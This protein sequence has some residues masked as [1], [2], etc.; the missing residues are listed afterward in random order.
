PAAAPSPATGA[1]APV[2]TTTSSTPPA[3]SQGATGN[4]PPEPASPPTS[5]RPPRRRA[6][7]AGQPAAAPPRATT[8]R[9]RSYGTDHRRR[10][11]EQRPHQPHR[12]PDA[13]RKPPL[14]SVLAPRPL[15][16]PQQRHH[17]HGPRRR[18]R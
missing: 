17:R 16:G 13:R 1:P 11:H 5:T 15:P 7:R 2:S 14:G 6:T 9:G 18:D 10:Q 3:T 4:P 12:P 8:A